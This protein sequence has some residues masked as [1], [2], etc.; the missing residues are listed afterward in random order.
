MSQRNTAQARGKALDL[1]QAPPDAGAPVLCLATTFTFD[2]NFFESQCLDRFL[3][4]DNDAQES[5]TVGYLIE[6]E[7]KLRG[8]P[9]AVFVDRRHAREKQSWQWDILPVAIHGAVQHAKLTILCWAEYVRILVG[10]ANL[11]EP[12]Y[13]KNL[14][15]MGSIELSRRDGGPLQHVRDAAD[16]LDR[17]L[18]DGT[19]GDEKGKGPKQ[20]ARAS[21][22]TLRNHIR[23]WPNVKPS[24]TSPIPLFGGLGPSVFARLAELWPAGGPPRCAHILSPFFD[25]DSSDGTMAALLEIMAKRGQREMYVF[26]PWE[27]LPDGRTQI[28]SPRE[29]IEAARPSCD[30]F[31]HKVKHLQEAEPRPLH[32]KML[33]LANDDWEMWLLG[34]SNFTRAGFAV[35]ESSVNREANLVYRA[36]VGSPESRLLNALWPEIEDDAV[37]LDSDD[38][39]WQPR[40]NEE[41]EDGSE[42]VLSV[43]FREALYDAGS[44]PPS[45]ILS[46]GDGLPQRWSIQSSEGQTLLESERWSGGSGEFR[47]KW[48]CASPPFM[49]TVNWEN[50]DQPKRSASWPVNVVDPAALPPPEQLRNL[51]LE[52]FIE[53]LS[54]MRPLHE[55]VL[56]MLKRKSRGQENG[57]LLLDPHKR[58]STATFLLQRTQRFSGMLER[59]RER[60]EQ[61]VATREALDWRLNGPLGAVNL[62]IAI[63]KDAG[64]LDEACFFLAELALS[65]KR[66]R[67]GEAARGGLDEKTIRVNLHKCIRQIEDLASPILQV[68]ES[69][70]NS[71]VAT[72]F[73]E[74]KR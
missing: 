24:P 8:V 33:V 18:V 60:L 40:W 68:G 59:L 29:L 16:F 63:R 4:M 5:D 64:H 61:P 26:V 10:S 42:A 23:D 48:R 13:R 69:A 43:A 15:V 25:R 21:L 12:A 27:S 1:W 19:R 65:L 71:Y 37:E 56:R 28:F 70:M 53:I 47:L 54:S 66:V 58:V 20:R 39:V 50:D 74:A 67:A 7:E 22:N 45:L 62:A 49:L 35:T 72:A 55:S 41:G 57:D 52:D 51:S 36:R 2:A 34:S 9:V 73:K 30:V 46:L 6:R 32:A 11:T 17:L 14:E 44:Q 38:I 3:E 31:V